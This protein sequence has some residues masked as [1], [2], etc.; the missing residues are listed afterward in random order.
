MIA[1]T[2]S[3][4]NLVGDNLA[5]V[6][7]ALHSA[8]LVIG[9]ISDVVDNTCN[10]VGRVKGQYPPAGTAVAYGSAVSVYVG[11]RPPYPHQCP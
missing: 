8:G 2:A 3:V 5:A 4:P 1:G 11:E 6:G 10:Y 7:I 9:S